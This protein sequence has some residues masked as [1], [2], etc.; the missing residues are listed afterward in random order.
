MKETAQPTL[1]PPPARHEAHGKPRGCIDL[2][3]F[4][5]GC[6]YNLRTL[7]VWPDE[8]T[9]IPVVRCPECGRF[10]S[11]NDAA[12]VLRPWLN[13]A[14][15]VVLAA[16]I[17]F[18]I[19]VIGHLG[20]AEGALSY[21]TLDELTIWGGYT[22]Q[23]IGNRTITTYSGNLGPL[24]IRENYP[25]YEFFVALIMAIS[26]ATAFASSW[27]AVVAFPHWRRIAYL[28]LV[29]FLPIA[30]GGIVAGIWQQEA[31][32]LF[33]WGLK[34]MAAHVGVQLFGGLA[35]VAFGRPLARAIVRIIL[36]PG[37]RPRLAYLWLVDGKPPPK[38]RT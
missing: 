7:P 32:G 1:E 20:L 27:F 36:P 2:D 30:A 11:A 4:C 31:P 34:Y 17:L 26:F 16:W 14:T 24:E 8:R 22:T 13:R 3:R 9:G 29:C 25:Y 21:A 19:A 10:Q 18:A 28:G 6:G 23:Q 33:G 35:G 12:T 37:V 38:P 5:G 15:T